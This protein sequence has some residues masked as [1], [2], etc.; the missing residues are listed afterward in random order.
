MADRFV[1]ILK[2]RKFYSCIWRI[3]GISISRFIRN[4]KEEGEEEFRL[5]SFWASAGTKSI[6]RQSVT[7]QRWCVLTKNVLRAGSVCQKKTIYSNTNVQCYVS[8]KIRPCQ[9][10]ESLLRLS[11]LW[12]ELI[13]KE[14]PVSTL[15]N[16]VWIS[17]SLF[18]FISR[19]EEHNIH[20]VTFSISSYITN[21]IYKNI[22]YLVKYFSVTSIK[23]V[24]KNCLYSLIVRI[25]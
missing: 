25:Y 13:W 20:S 4:D 11:I 24:N 1:Y 16:T 21:T 8:W 14:G 12:D 7:N 10:T 23:D 22:L 6:Y 9:T 19:I 17:N 5:N 3:N 2:F 18:C 15:Y